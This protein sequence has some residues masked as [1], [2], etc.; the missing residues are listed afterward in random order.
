MLNFL[1]YGLAIA[2]ISLSCSVL[3]NEAPST[4]DIDKLL[5]SSN[6]D[7]AIEGARKHMHNMI[8]QMPRQMQLLPQHREIASPYMKKMTQLVDQEVTWDK[9]KAPISKVYAEL[10]S[11]AEIQSITDFYQTPAGKKLVE[12]TPQLMH[13]SM[14]AA[15]EIMTALTPQLQQLQQDMIAEIERVEKNKTAAQKI[16]E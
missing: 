9:V 16:T 5:M 6:A 2:S 14:Q 7:Q 10:F 3:S 11:A 15:Q 13:S 4:A 1:R 12:K 8:K